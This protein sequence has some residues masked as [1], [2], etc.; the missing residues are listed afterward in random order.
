M[1]GTL[2]INEETHTS[3]VFNG[4]HIDRITSCI[5]RNCVFKNC[6]F[7]EATISLSVFHDCEFI[8]CSFAKSLWLHN[9]QKG[10]RL[11]YSFVDWSSDIPHIYYFPDT[12]LVVT[13]EYGFA[14]EFS[15]F[16]V[17]LGQLADRGIV[18]EGVAEVI[19]A[20]LAIKKRREDCD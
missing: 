10:R 8:N 12:D 13:D 14:S 18:L 7:D 16:L 17:F 19:D 2:V 1:K 5:F 15:D 4:Y 11:Y 9:R 3:R 20:I 6:K